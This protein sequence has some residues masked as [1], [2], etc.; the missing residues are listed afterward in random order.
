MIG[1]AVVETG[2]KKRT[3]IERPKRASERRAGKRMAKKRGCTSPLGCTGSAGLLPPTA[4]VWS[5]EIFASRSPAGVRRTNSKQESDK[6][7]WRF[8]RGSL[9]TNTGKYC[10]DPERETVRSKKTKALDRGDLFGM[11][12]RLAVL[13]E[14]TPT[15]RHKDQARL[16]C[17]PGR[18]K[19]ASWV[20]LSPS[21][22]CSKQLT[23]RELL[24]GFVWCVERK[25]KGREKEEGQPALA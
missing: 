16:W 23:A 4:Q 17:V 25:L 13:E 8:L 11:I 9:L 22:M 7:R 15:S 12:C 2:W 18:A 1:D 6:G 3:K 19:G 10:R 14:R 24:R 21:M 20:L 5:P